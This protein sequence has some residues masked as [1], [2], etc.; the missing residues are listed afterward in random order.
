MTHTLLFIVC[1]FLLG[2]LPS[3]TVW[4][5]AHQEKTTTGYSIPKVIPEKDTITVTESIH[6]SFD[7][8]N[9]GDEPMTSFEAF[10]QINNSEPVSEIKTGY[11]IIVGGEERVTFLQKIAQLKQGNYKIKV[12]IS[13]INGHETNLKITTS[14]LVVVPEFFPKRKAMIEVFTSSTCV[15]CAQT[16]VWLTPF[17][18]EKS[19]DCVITK[20]QMDWPAPGDPYFTTEA[21]L[22][23]RF[24]NVIGYP[25]IYVDGTYHFHNPDLVKPAI[26]AAIADNKP[27]VDIK[28]AY[29]VSGS[30]IT[31]QVS[32]LPNITGSYRIYTNVDE[33]M[34]TENATTNGETEFFHVMMRML[35][36]EVGSTQYFTAGQPVYLNFTYNLAES[37]MEEYD[38]TEVAIFVQHF[39]SKKILNAEYAVKTNTTVSL[40]VPS[41]PSVDMEKNNIVLNWKAPSSTTG[42]SGYNIYRNGIKIASNVASTIYEDKA[43]PQGTHTYWIAASYSEAE[44]PYIVIDA[45]VFPDIEPPTNVTVETSDYKTFE[46]RWSKPNTGGITGYNIYRQG[47]KI[48]S[49]PLTSTSY[50]DNVV[51]EGYYC[52]TLTTLTPLGESPHS[53]KGCVS[54]GV[55][56]PENVE[57]S[58]P[59]K[60]KKV[61][62]ITWNKVED[63]SI[64]GYNVYRNEQLLTQTPLKETSFTDNVPEFEEYCYMITAVQGDKESLK[65]APACI[66]V[67]GDVSINNGE[68]KKQALIYPNPTDSYLRIESESAVT[69]IAIYDLQG[70]MLFEASP[71]GNT[72]DVNALATGIY[73]LQIETLFGKSI[74]KF[75]KK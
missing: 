25:S 73:L 21:H 15:P 20:Y 52:Y 64:N 1:S 19:E 74:H 72:I 2:L 6:L 17:L 61:V 30:I 13:R 9:T 39:A 29:Q 7:L 66:L 10:Y 44:S 56:S 45:V 75:V 12:W 38:D 51:Y 23:G 55:P 3:S 70:R 65:S 22:R 67:N 4:A 11:N 69:S 31:V 27:Q 41:S 42:L 54:S 57:A 47:T 18:N 68:A 49:A 24:Y 58:Q 34:T 71:A 43:V 8:K 46:V 14:D 26:E 62:L 28:G 53:E 37:N 16:N 60:G 40:R 5:N 35:P 50:T 48:N 32:V 36:T 59:E 63:V 33:K